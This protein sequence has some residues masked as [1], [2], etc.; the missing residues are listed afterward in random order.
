MTYQDYLDK[1]DNVDVFEFTDEEWEDFIRLATEEVRAGRPICWFT[2]DK[3]FEYYSYEDGDILEEFRHGW[4]LKEMILKINENENYMASVASHDDHGWEYDEQALEP[5]ELRE[6]KVKKW[7]SKNEPIEKEKVFLVRRFCRDT[8]HDIF[9]GVFKTFDGAKNYIL[10]WADYNVEDA[11]EYGISK[12]VVDEAEVL[13]QN[14]IR[15]FG[16]LKEKDFNRYYFASSFDIIKT[17]LQ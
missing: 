14:I 10:G 17:Y 5:V 3:L 15:N 9:E 2:F 6:I 8:G 12:E 11:K 7:V 4:V 16:D 1:A 13:K